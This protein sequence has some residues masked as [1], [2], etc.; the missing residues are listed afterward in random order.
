[1]HPALPHHHLEVNGSSDHLLDSSILRKSEEVAGFGF[2]SNS[3][4]RTAAAP[5]SAFASVSGRNHRSS[6]C[7]AIEGATNCKTN[8]I[9]RNEDDMKTVTLQVS[10][11]EEI[12]RRALDAFK[13]QKFDNRISFASPELLFPIMTAKRWQLIRAMTGAGPLTIRE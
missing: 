9:G 11:R 3:S 10:T 5:V 7:G 13:G 6:E 1:V 2:T 8:P 12:K 4:T